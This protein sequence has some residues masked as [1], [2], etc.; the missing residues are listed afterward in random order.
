[1]HIYIYIYSLYNTS[2]RNFFPFFIFTHLTFALQQLTFIYGK[3]ISLV[4][5]RF[6]I[7]FFFIF[8]YVCFF[9]FCNSNS[10]VVYVCMYVYVVCEEIKLNGIATSKDRSRFF[11]KRARLGVFFFLFFLTR[12]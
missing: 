6:H 12:Y 5:L 10:K 3:Y 4:F 2:S 11:L 8:L 7:F 9:I 1:M